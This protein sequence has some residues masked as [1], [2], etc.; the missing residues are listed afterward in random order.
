MFPSGTFHNSLD[1]PRLLYKVS[2]FFIKL[3]SV[4]FG[5]PPFSGWFKALLLQNSNLYSTV[6]QNS[7]RKLKKNIKKHRPAEKSREDM[8][9]C[10]KF[11]KC[12][13]PISGKVCKILV[14]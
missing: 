10:S 2:F 9:T 13:F 6:I 1:L 8:K 12:F 4:F 14:F 7:S 3:L 11:G 5:I